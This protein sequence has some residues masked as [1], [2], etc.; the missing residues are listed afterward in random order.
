MVQAKPT[1]IGPVMIVNKAE[2]CGC[3]CH[4]QDPWHKASYQRVVTLDEGSTTRGTVRMPY[5][6]QPVRVWLHPS[7]LNHMLK[8]QMWFVVRTSIVFDK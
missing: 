7:S 1:K 4:G 3:G 6:T 5:S 2:A 8:Y